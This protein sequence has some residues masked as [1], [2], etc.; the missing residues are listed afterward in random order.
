MSLHKRGASPILQYEFN[1]KG[2]T[3]RK[4]TGTADR[5]A[6]EKIEREAKAAARSEQVPIVAAQET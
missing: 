5:R 2:V 4:S 1:V 6:A 3:Y